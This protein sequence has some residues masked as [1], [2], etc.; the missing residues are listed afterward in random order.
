MSFAALTGISPAI[1]AD[2]KQGRPRTVE[3]TSAHNII[4]LSGVKAGDHVFITSL[5]CADLGPGD[6]GI[7]VEVNSVAI[8]MKRIIEFTNPMFFEER[9]RMAAR[10]QVK[11]CGTSVVKHIESRGMGRPVLVDVVKTTCYHAH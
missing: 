2:L 5:D 9:E 6:S 8:S 7:M 4:T 10:M 11:Y 3:L 1:L